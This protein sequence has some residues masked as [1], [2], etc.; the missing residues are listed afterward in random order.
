MSIWSKYYLFCYVSHFACKIM[1]EFVLCVKSF[2][3]LSFIHPFTKA[4]IY[5]NPVLGI[6]SKLTA[7]KALENL[8]I[9]AV[10]GRL[11][12][13]SL[14]QLPNENLLRCWLRQ[15]AIKIACYNYRHNDRWLHFLHVKHLVSQL[16]IL[17]LLIKI[18]LCKYSPGAGH[19]CVCIKDPSGSNI[20]T[21]T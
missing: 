18:C 14:M 12:M 6:M 7:V 8:A 20:H 10:S 11:W 2:I 17:D 3:M 19:I 13:K 15:S 9:W 1:N 4:Y 16:K 5:W 21:H